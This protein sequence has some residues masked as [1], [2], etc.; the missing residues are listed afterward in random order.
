MVKDTHYQKKNFIA[1]NCEEFLLCV[2][3]WYYK[4]IFLQ[5]VQQ[6]DDPIYEILLGKK[7]KQFFFF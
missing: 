5:L 4:N 3:R 7:K 1:W 2:M 6:A